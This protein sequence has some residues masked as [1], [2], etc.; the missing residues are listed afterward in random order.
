MESPQPRVENMSLLTSFLQLLAG[1]SNEAVLNA[2]SAERVI[3]SDFSKWLWSQWQRLSSLN[4]DFL[5]DFVIPH[6]G[7]I[8]SVTFPQEMAQ[9]S[10]KKSV[11]L[12][13]VL[14]PFLFFAILNI[15]WQGV[16]WLCAFIHLCNLSTDLRKSVDEDIMPD[17][18]KAHGLLRWR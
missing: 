4:S 17:E 11:L 8:E 6:R 15:N 18:L 10:M 5:Q 13:G 12:P 2:A 7:E 3:C 16:S 9:Q 1:S 14:V